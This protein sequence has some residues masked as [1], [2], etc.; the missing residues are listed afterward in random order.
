MGLCWITLDWIDAL[1][2][3]VASVTP[4]PSAVMSLS[5]FDVRDVD[6]QRLLGIIMQRCGVAADCEMY[7]GS[8]FGHFG[9]DLV[10]GCQQ[11]IC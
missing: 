9:H 6:K 10:S 4:S 7:D 1:V 5:F 2:A 3:I 11:R 8:L